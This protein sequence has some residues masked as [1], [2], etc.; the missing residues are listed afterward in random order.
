MSR[1][2]GLEE[3]VS[4]LQLLI[5]RVDYDGAAKACSIT[6]RARPGPA[7]LASLGADAQRAG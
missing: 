3:R 4:L 7:R 1:G 2:A 6:F 5:D